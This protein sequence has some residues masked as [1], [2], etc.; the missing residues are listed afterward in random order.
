MR[1]LIVDDQSSQRTMMR[2]L[3]GDIS[4]EIKVADFS[5]P[6]H[7]LLWS[8][9]E[10][11]DLVILDY[12]MPKMD[13]L[14]FAR[15]FRRPLS[16][17]DVPIILVT[18]VGD[19]PVRQAALEAG[20]IDFLVK[21]VRPRE[22]RQRCK[23]LLELRQRQQSLKSRA[24]FLERQLLSGMHE[25]EH[26]ERDLLRRLALAANWRAGSDPGGIERISGYSGLLAEGCGLPDD[27]VLLIEQAAPLRDVGN[28]RVSDRLLGKPAVLT[29]DEMNEVRRHT[30]LGHEIL[31]DSNSVFVQM[32]DEIAL[33]HHERWDGSGYPRDLRGKEIPISARIVAIADVL[34]A[35]TTPRP[36]RAPV[37]L[38]AAVDWIKAKAGELFDPELVKILLAKQVDVL[39]VARSFAPPAAHN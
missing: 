10:P 20:V 37:P 35:M 38:A 26:R 11:P 31:G 5:D 36:Y 30:L 2:Q 18:V 15:R 4:P 22:L 1:V 13:G 12:R 34:D 14:E 21:P 27:E 3:L 16:Q 28:I 33:N 19:E 32:A 39:N 6:V 29:S 25:I 24:Y 17:R 7:A 8:Q 23:N 9:E